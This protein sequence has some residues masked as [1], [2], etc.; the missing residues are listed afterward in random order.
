MDKDRQRWD[1]RG[2]KGGAK[3]G[4]QRER[5]RERERETERE[6]E[7][8]R[9]VPSSKKMKST[10]FRWRVGAHVGEASGAA[11]TGLRSLR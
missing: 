11:R 3:K 5:E 8:E 4:R 6:G 10:R 7:R 1:A 9:A 2:R